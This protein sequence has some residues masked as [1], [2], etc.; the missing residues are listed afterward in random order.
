M[1]KEIFLF[2]LK[3]W[4]K[5]KAFYV[6]AAI[7]FGI[8]FLM[9]LAAVGIFDSVKATTSGL[10]YINSPN[11]IFEFIEGF[12]SILYFLFPAIIGSSA[13]RDYKDNVHN[14][15]YSYPFTKA[16]YLSAKFLSGFV[17]VLSISILIGL[18]LFLATVFPNAN[19]ELIGPNH[20]WSYVQ[21]YLLSVL[22]NML[23]I[24]LIAFIVTTMFRNVYYGFIAILILSLGSDLAN[25]LA[26]NLD[27]KV[28]GAL[29]DSSGSNAIQYYTEHW[30][31]DE[32]NNND[33]P[34]GKWYLVNRLIWLGVSA[35]LA[36]FM[37]KWFSFSQQPLSF[38]R[39][40]KTESVVKGNFS[41][42]AEHVLPKADY[43]FD[44]AARVKTMLH[45][46]KIDFK[47]ILKNPGF[48]ILGGIGLLI[49]ISTYF[50]SGEIFG[51][52]VLP[53]T[54]NMLLFGDMLSSFLS[55]I[56]TFLIAGLLVHRG[57]LTKMNQLIDVTAVPNWVLFGSKLLAIVMIQVVL[58][59]ISALAG[60]FFQVYQGFYDFEF[61][62]YFRQLL[63]INLIGLVIW[64]ILALTVQTLFKNYLLGFMVLLAFFLFRRYLSKL[65]IEQDIFYFNRLPPPSYSDLNGYGGMLPSYYLYALY[66]LMFCVGLGGIALLLWRRG[67]FS[68]VKER[69]QIARQ[70]ATGSVLLPSLIGFLSFAGLGGYI[71][72]QNNVVNIFTS[73]KE[74][75]TQRIDF[76]KQYKR[77]EKLAQPRIVDVK[78]NMDIYPETR[79]FKS[80]GKYIIKN[81]HNSPIDTLMLLLPNTDNNIY[82]IEVKNARE[83]FK[84]NRL[85]VMLFRFGEALQP[86]AESDISFTV[87]NKPN[88]WVK[89]NSGVLKSG[90]FMNNGEF[91]S[92]GYNDAYE[93]SDDAV[94]KKYGLQPKEL[95][96]DQDNVVALQNTY[97]SNDA[98]WITFEATVSTSPDQI[99]IAPGY[100]QKEWTENNRRYFHY[101]MDQEMLNF[102]AFNSAR[103]EVAKDKW[104]DVNL[105]IYY[106][107]PH[108]YNIDR[109]MKG[110]KKGLQYCSDNFSPYQHKQARIIEFPVVMGTFAQSFANTIPFS[111]GF[112]FIA[113]VDEKDENAADYP[114]LVTAHE[115]AHQWWAHQVIGA[116]VK[117]ATMLSESLAEYV[118]LKVLEHEYGKGQMRRFLKEELDG[119]L[120]GRQFESKKENPLM[121][122][123][124]QQY[125]R[126][127]K[128][129]MVFYAMSEYLGEENL[130]KV[131]KTYLEKVAYQEPPYTTA[132]EL[133]ADLKAATPDSLQYL[134][135]DMFETIT[136]YDNHIVD[137]SVKKTPDGKY[138]VKFSTITSKYRTDD[139]GKKIYADQNGKTLTYKNGKKRKI[140]S[141]PLSDYVEVGIFSKEKDGKAKNKDKI[142][143]LQKVRFDDIHR[144]FTIVV[145]EEPT[146]VG[147]D[148]YNKLIDANSEDNR[149]SVSVSAVKTGK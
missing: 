16:E 102:Y 135:K 76:E 48:L 90:T 8:A 147:I 11:S 85:G 142:L 45:L 74:A 149:K 108:T 51:T 64:A 110:L 124:G 23:F 94:R 113:K 79:D 33:L 13:Y 99:A 69:L 54:R 132:G 140:E 83:I 27:H 22:P 120:K 38:G 75:E 134:I 2:E 143:Y 67:V 119:Y 100:L 123:E 9:A 77:Y 21:V 105:E 95:M 81:K 70:R 111:E 18:A 17:A 19:P 128:G 7:F 82:S 60:I 26:Q 35:L 68:G 114:F 62:L 118:C 101:K 65:G 10:K 106:H 72:Y 44:F 14:I 55:V 84:D 47:Y 125:I 57:E 30:T 28:V 63:G 41:G 97:I 12:N 42:F 25:S 78:V 24:G 66:W 20:L 87:S 96:A 115:I 107:K 58:L 40:A 127:Q 112:G 98:D 15:L 133:V 50:V 73:S 34:L 92:I 3:Y 136:L 61:G 146:E 1:F 39:K 104:N 109:M 37:Y 126:Y 56:I 31:I 32:V 137:A 122:N 141:L 59:A 117:G 138:E 5:N 129:A 43:R 53:V 121:Y 116:N 4:F 144:D 89:S 131:L 103:Y 91:P 29:L 145:D 71:Y 148:P 52:S 80:S 86:G 49:L 93:I 6:Y 36:V 139:K 46:S 130:N 88:S